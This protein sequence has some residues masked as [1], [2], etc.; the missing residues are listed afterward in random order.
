MH[1]RKITFRAILLLTYSVLF[2]ISGWSSEKKNIAVLD[3]EA[4][5]INELEAKVLTNRL[6]TIL[7][8]YPQYQLIERGKMVQILEEQQFQLSGCTSDECVVEIGQ[9]L[10]VE[11]MLAGSFGLVGS[12]YTI[13][14]RIIDVT[15][16]MVIATSKYN[17]KGKIDDVLEFGLNDA[18]N[19]LLNV[20]KS[21]ATLVITSLPSGAAVSLNGTSKGIT[22]LTISNTITGETKCTVTITQAGYQPLSREVSL[23]PGQ[24]LPLNFVL[25][26]AQGFLSATGAPPGAK[27]AVNWQ[28]LGKAPITKYALAV[29][30]Y[31]FTATK[32]EY[33]SFRQ[34]VAITENA[35]LEITYSLKPLSQTRAFFYSCLI[36]GGGQIYQKYNV[37]GILFLAATAFVGYST[38]DAHQDYLNRKDLWIEKRDTYNRNLTKPELWPTQLREL[39]TAFDQM[40]EVEKTRNLWLGGLGLTW[41]VNIVE[42]LW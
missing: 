2:S 3:F 37:K 19:S 22:P 39:N 10:G 21:L 4:L 25:E 1:I 34:K 20:K 27:I 33:A 15:T 14:M 38:L 6:R 35:P 23:E 40:K 16:G 30:E 11:Q 32:P 13:D 7:S 12:T 42:I 24:N 36:P 31:Q 28:N 29:G 41:T 8:T 18:L 26:K 9:L 17:L 5:V